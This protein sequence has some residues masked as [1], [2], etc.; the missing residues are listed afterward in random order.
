LLFPFFF[1]SDIKNAHGE[2]QIILIHINIIFANYGE[3]IFIV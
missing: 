2:A 1:N 3:I